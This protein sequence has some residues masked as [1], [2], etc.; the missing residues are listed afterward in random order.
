MSDGGFRNA[1]IEL[2]DAIDRGSPLTAALESQQG[3]IP[4]HIRGLVY[5]GLRTGKLGDVLGRF[6]SYAS[7]G[8]ELRRGLWL[9]VAYPL[10][11][12]LLAFALLMLV[13]GFLVAQFENIF[14]DFGIP[15]P[16]LTIVLIETSRMVRAGWPVLAI[17]LGLII[18]GW[19]VT[20]FLLPAPMRNSLIGRIPVIGPLWRYTS[21]AEFCHLLALLL[22]SELPMPD[23]LRLT[24]QGIQNSDIDRACRA[25]AND[26]E[27][28]KTLSDAMSGRVP[29]IKAS[30]PFDHLDPKH[31][32]KPPA[33]PMENLLSAREAAAAVR[34]GHAEEPGPAFEMGREPPG[35]RRDPPHVGRDV[36][37]PVAFASVLR[38]HGDGRAR[39]VRRDHGGLHRSRGA[40]AA[41]DHAV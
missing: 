27:N 9:G 20:R 36:R 29:I 33:L 10:F 38:R 8:T 5:G 26:V 14:R 34:P 35:D 30:G 25:M 12:I 37:G 1:L 4:A 22:E 39:G 24:G 2:A 19:L 18:V 3:R 7:I 31:P 16:K 32:E 21:W 40:D 41:V 13:D 15:L 6:S 23:A 28:G 17:L 11:T